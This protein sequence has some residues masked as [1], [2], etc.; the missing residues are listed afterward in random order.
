MSL[1]LSLYL[2]I[3]LY[4]NHYIFYPYYCIFFF[5]YVYLTLPIYN[6]GKMLAWVSIIQLIS[7][8][9]F[10][11]HFRILKYYWKIIYCNIYLLYASTRH[12]SSTDPSL[13]KNYWLANQLQT[14]WQHLYHF[15]SCQCV[16]FWSF[17]GIKSRSYIL[18]CGS[19]IAGP[20][21]PHIFLGCIGVPL[22]S[23]TFVLSKCIKCSL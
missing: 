21:S 2:S 4:L 17:L 5:I 13:L 12:S 16:C 20:C 8:V 23:K 22:P 14:Q 6:A 7:D 19:I 1:S 10:Q 3:Y 18:L 9:Y 15:P 11:S